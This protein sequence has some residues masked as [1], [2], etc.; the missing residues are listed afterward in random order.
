MRKILPLLALLAAL[1]IPAHATTYYISYSTGSNSNNGLTKAAAWKSDP[2]M[3]NASGCAGTLPSYSHAAGDQH[4]FM[5]GDSWPNACFFLNPTNS[6]SSGNPDYFGVDK[7][8]WNSGVCGASWCQPIADFQNT[9][10][11]GVSGNGYASMFCPVCGPGGASWLTLDNWEVKNI[12]WDHNSPQSEFGVFAMGNN[13]CNIV[14]ENVYVHHWTHENAGGNPRG[15][16]VGDWLQMTDQPS[17]PAPATSC[18]ITFQ[19][20]TFDNTDGSCDSG[21]FGIVYKISGNIFRCVPNVVPTGINYFFDHNIIAGMPNSFDDQANSNCLACIHENAYEGTLDACG[22]TQYVNDNLVYDTS[23]HGVTFFLDPAFG[24]T[25]VG[26]STLYVYNNVIYNSTNA[27]PIYFD[28]DCGGSSPNCAANIAA[29]T[30]VA[31]N[32]TID[33]TNAGTTN[34]ETCF[35]V[36][37]RNTS[38]IGTGIIQNNHCITGTGSTVG[39]DTGVG[40]TSS[41]ISNNITQTYAAAQTAGYTPANTYR[42]TSSSSP[43][44]AAGVNLTTNC[45]GLLTPLCSDA[46]GVWNTAG[47]AFGSG[48]NNPRPASTAWDLGAYR[49]GASAPPPGPP[50]VS[51]LSNNLPEATVGTPYSVTLAATGGTP[52]YTWSS[53]GFTSGLLLTASGVLAGT[54]NLAG[55]SNVT[56]TATD[57]IGASSSASLSLIVNPLVVSGGVPGPQGPPGPTGPTGLQGPQGPAGPQGPVGATGATGATGAKGATGATGATGPAGPQGPTGNGMLCK[58]VS[59]TSCTITITVQ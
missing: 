25:C 58:K 50:P 16:G 2:Y 32:N 49:F 55:T 46:N 42:P 39:Y 3:Q 31:W 51:I 33:A 22:A 53:S 44:V 47:T 24:L 19:N 41:T 28:T 48:V 11:P 45:S 12:Y 57:S 8:W 37:A 6:G 54:P 4:I 15:S 36:I 20:N 38:F 30:V 29:S 5:G 21:Q 17:S 35:R 59:A 10:Q 52:P 18:P 9:V 27:N 34:G 40:F 13:V 1:V 7:T 56:V 14:I 43:T 23:S 26:S